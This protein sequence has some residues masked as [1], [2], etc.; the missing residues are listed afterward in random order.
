MNEQVLINITCKCGRTFSSMIDEKNILPSG[1]LTYRPMCK[2]CRLAKEHLSRG[3][4][5]AAL[6]SKH[7]VAMQTTSAVKIFSEEEKLDF[8]R[9][10]NGLSLSKRME[11]SQ[12]T[13]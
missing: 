2:V 5:V 10:R 3:K 6:H 4:S 9:R 13:E 12:K 11:K 7:A 8:E 1:K